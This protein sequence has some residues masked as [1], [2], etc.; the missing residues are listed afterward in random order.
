MG[1]T[2]EG[3]FDQNLEREEAMQMSAGNIPARGI[4]QCKA[5]RQ[6]VPAWERSSQEAIEAD[7]ER[8]G[9]G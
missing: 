7:A 2:E 9:R 3:M 6:N 4:S 5:L 1:L 8:G